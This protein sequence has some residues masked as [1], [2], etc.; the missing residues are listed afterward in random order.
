VW[1]IIIPF[2]PY[3]GLFDFEKTIRW[4]RTSEP[5]GCSPQG[6][7]AMSYSFKGFESSQWVHLGKTRGRA[8]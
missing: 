2:G 1:V 6:L 5:T 3:R 4:V 7:G 8:R